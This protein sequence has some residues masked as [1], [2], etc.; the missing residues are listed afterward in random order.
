MF[1]HI[2]MNTDYQ[3]RVLQYGHADNWRKCSERCAYYKFNTISKYVFLC[4]FNIFGLATNFLIMPKDISVEGY[5]KSN[6]HEAQTRRDEEQYPCRI[7][8]MPIFTRK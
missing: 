4:V 1:F 6:K 3:G 2:E 8:F 5:Q 7:N